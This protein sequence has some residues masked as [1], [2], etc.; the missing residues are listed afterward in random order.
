MSDPT[1]TGRGAVWLARLTG[2][3]E[4]GGSNPLAPINKLLETKDLRHTWACV[5]LS[6]LLAGPPPWPAGIDGLARSVSVVDEIDKFI[7]TTGTKMPE[8]ILPMRLVCS[9]GMGWCD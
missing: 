1:K 7:K 6:F 5:L 4:V 3:Q 8:M 2:G 9:S